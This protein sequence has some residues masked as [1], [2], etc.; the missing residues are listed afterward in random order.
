[1][2]AQ[3]GHNGIQIQDAQTLP[4]VPV[5]QN[6]VQLGIVVGD[7]QGQFTGFPHFL[8]NTSDLLLL[9]GESNLFLHTGQT[10]HGIGSDGFLQLTE[11]V[12]GVVEFGNGFVQRV[13][14]EVGQLMLEPTKGNSALVEILI[15]F[16]HIQTETANVIVHSPVFIILVPMAEGAV[17][18]GGDKMKTAVGIILCFPKIIGN[19]SGVFHDLYRVLEYVFIDSLQNIF[20]AG[21][22]LDFQRMVNMSVTE[23]LTG[24]GGS[25]GHKCKSSLF[26]LHEI[27]LNYSAKRYSIIK[28]SKMQSKFAFF[29]T[30]LGV[31]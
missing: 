13:S 22:G 5:Q 14:G 11:P 23:L 3:T 31:L 20:C 12:N 7:P 21:I 9:E 16:R 6:I 4:G 18:L 30:K 24:N 2:N 10:T 15:R 29:S 25:V 27:H 17:G 28:L 19:S 1:M 8:Q 26:D